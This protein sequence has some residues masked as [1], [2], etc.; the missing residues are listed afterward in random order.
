MNLPCI[1]IPALVGI[2]CGILGYLI[3]KR[4]SK[5]GD[6]SSFLNLQSDLDNCRSNTQKLN[7]K[8]SDLETKLNVSV[9]NT[10]T[11]ASNVIPLIRFNS[12]LSSSI[13]G[14]KV[15]EN[16]LKIIEGI[17]P[18]IE[19]L[20]HNAGIDTWL[21]LSQTSIEKLQFILNAGGENFAMHNPGTWAR[22]AELAYKGKWQ[23]LKDWQ[24]A[25]DGG[26]E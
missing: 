8:I 6:N 10:Q 7:T 26:K 23:E 22:Q 15:K 3:A 11:L 19:E 1:L 9:N 12:E 4:N 16:D 20:Y 2:I 18:K 14:K 5:D 24:D 25:L 17:G 13:L 21:K